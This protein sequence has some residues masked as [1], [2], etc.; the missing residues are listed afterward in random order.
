MSRSLLNIVAYLKIQHIKHLWFLS[1]EFWN[2]VWKEFVP[3]SARSSPISQ[4]DPFVKFR[5][6]PWD[7]KPSKNQATITKFQVVNQ[8]ILPTHHSSGL[9]TS[10]S[11][12]FTPWSKRFSKPGVKSRRKMDQFASHLMLVVL[13]IQRCCNVPDRLGSRRWRARV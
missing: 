13:R 1:D 8:Q 7:S 12:L 3:I 10:Y 6:N 11:P 2:P 4:N 9:S 5:L